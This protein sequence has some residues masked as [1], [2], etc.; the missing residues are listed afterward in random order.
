MN[1]WLGCIKK[2][3]IYI[4]VK[5]IAKEYLKQDCGLS[6]KHIFGQWLEEIYVL[7]YSLL[8]DLFAVKKS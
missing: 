1:L 3:W 5:I 2:T 8:Q 4:V 7:E 6:N